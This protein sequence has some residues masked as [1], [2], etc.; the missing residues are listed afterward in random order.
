MKMY[1]LIHYKSKFAKFS[2]GIQITDVFLI[3]G[4]ECSARTSHTVLQS[5]H[6]IS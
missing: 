3:V 1:V 2:T 4:S 6:T 5:H